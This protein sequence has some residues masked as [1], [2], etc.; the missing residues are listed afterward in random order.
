MIAVLCTRACALGPSS[1]RDRTHASAHHR[2]RVVRRQPGRPFRTCFITHYGFHCSN[3]LFTTFS[4]C[5]L[6]YRAA[7][8]IILLSPWLMMI[9]DFNKLMRGGAS[10]NHFSRTTAGMCKFTIRRALRQ[11]DCR[12]GTH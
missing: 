6:P 10:T 8:P 4:L 12:S 2:T 7:P 1:K 5:L 9:N 3:A 11:R